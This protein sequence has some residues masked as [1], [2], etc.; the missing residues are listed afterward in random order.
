MQTLVYENYSKFIS[1]TDAIRSIGQSVDLSNEGLDRL[2]EKM[3]NMERNTRVLEEG[4]MQKRRQVVE[5]LKLKRLLNRLTRLVELPETLKGMRI[6]CQYRFLMRDYLDAMSILTQHTENF[7]SLKNIEGECNEIVKGMIHDV[8][9]KMW[10]WCGGNMN[11]NMGRRRRRTR[12]GKSGV[13]DRF[14]MSGGRLSGAADGQLM[15]VVPAADVGEIYECAGAL[16]VYAKNKQSQK[17]GGSSSS[18]SG[19]D[20][21]DGQANDQNEDQNEDDVLAQLT[22]EECRAMALESITMYLEGLLEDH[23]I[24]VQEGKDN[25]ETKDLSLYPSKFLDSL[26]EAATLY[27]VTF[28]SKSI[29]GSSIKE[30]ESGWDAELLTEY[31]SIWF[32]SFL[33]HVKNILL[34]QALEKNGDDERE[35]EDDDEVFAAV[36]RE[37]MKLVRSVREVASG[38]ALPEVGLDMEVASSLVEEAVGT[39]ES[40]VRRRVMQKFRLL[41]VRVM[42]ECI[43]PFV[44]TV[45]E[46]VTSADKAAIVKTVQSANITLSDGMQ[47]VDDTIRSIL[48]NSSDGNMSNVSLDS[49]MVKLA[50]RKN[51]RT[52]AFWLAASLEAIAGSEP[53]NNDITLDV[54]PMAKDDDDDNLQANK[55]ALQAVAVDCENADDGEEKKA[56]S[57]DQ[58]LIQEISEYIQD[59]STDASIDVLNIAL[60]EMC[61][62]AERNVS[63]N[64]KQSIS[65]SIEDTKVKVDFFKQTKQ[66][67][68]GIDSDQL[69][70]TRF[71]I[72]ASRS[73]E[74]YARTKGHEAA[75]SACHDAFE[76][77]SIQSEFFPHGPSD[78][79]MKILEVAKRIC[80]DCSAAFGGNAMASALPDFSNDYRQD[81]T[82]TGSLSGSRMTGGGNGAIKGLSLDVARMFIQKVQIY[83][84]PL[85][86]A[87]F[88]RDGVVSSMLK[89]ACKA[90]IEQIRQC[91]FTAF[92]YR[93]IQVDIEF[94]KYLLPHYVGEDSIESVQT[95]LS[96]V[97]L[98]VGERCKDIECVGVAEYYDEAMGK[99]LSPLSI[100]LGWLKEE[101][102][103][104]GRGALDQ[105]VIRKE[106][107]ETTRS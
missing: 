38:L 17:R 64:I 40:M 82:M 84:H 57:M 27:G 23:A 3:E 18:S 43:V 107:K 51:A 9:L 65:S 63:T 103:A 37:L 29:H 60:V 56:N 48:C 67:Q 28:R 46:D 12:V 1:A 66:D 5:K 85:D 76:S 55:I 78:A 47:F 100:A 97:V 4:L 45:L 42:K 16:L 92:A 80:V 31:V 61:R 98:N 19:E 58:I 14:W 24:D 7:E 2:H 94:L 36:S 32:T 75:S 6:K 90:W 8:G 88:T 10:V 104:G 41:R 95:M 44:K 89:V 86:M 39:T 74:I 73:L 15:D 70:S 50:V 20:E 102:A 101:A 59:N 13:L 87:N 105:F 71:R 35:E 72:A 79:A 26:L 77:C 33:A 96:D 83:A 11:V 34:Q 53:A 54:R 62:L 69:V 91:T 30:E 22:E 106:V 93:Q 21:D 68:D 25:H 49:G 81:M 52:F 99:V